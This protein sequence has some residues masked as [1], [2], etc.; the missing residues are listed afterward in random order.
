MAF[1]PKF[2]TPIT[3]DV[4]FTA[5][6]TGFSDRTST[7]NVNFSGSSPNVTVGQNA[8]GAVTFKGVTAN[9]MLNG[10]P[11]GRYEWT[12]AGRDGDGQSWQRRPPVHRVDRI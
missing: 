8:I 2:G 9:Q 11:D 4:D 3:G 12:S 6:A 10:R 1:V 7:Y 5:K